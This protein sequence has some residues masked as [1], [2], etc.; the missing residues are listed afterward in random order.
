MRTWPR[1]SGNQFEGG[2]PGMLGLQP[3]YMQ[4]EGHA[5][6][7]VPWSPGQS[8]LTLPCPCGSQGGVTPTGTGQTPPYREG[9][10]GLNW[11]VGMGIASVISFFT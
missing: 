7:R 6:W 5:V 9:A 10:A 2:V 3:P 4:E 1:L 8:H 11:G